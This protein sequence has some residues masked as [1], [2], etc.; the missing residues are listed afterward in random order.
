[1][2]DNLDDGWLFWL[3]WLREIAPDNAVE[4]AALEADRGRYLG[5]A[6]AVGRRRAD[7]PLYEPIVSVPMQYTERP[8]LRS[9]EESAR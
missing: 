3:A 5:Y 9:S 1:M 6:R 2:A 4:I 8:L 7:A